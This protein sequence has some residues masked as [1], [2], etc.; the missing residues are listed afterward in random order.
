MMHYG[1]Q[2]TAIK[3]KKNGTNAL[4]SR[5]EIE[6]EVQASKDEQRGSRFKSAWKRFWAEPIFAV[7][8]IIVSI[9]LLIFILLPLFAVLLR[10]FGIGDEGFTLDNYKQ[11]F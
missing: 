7:A 2:T 5:G 11:F 3:S 4:T 10:S 9:L 8:A 1:Q 6:L